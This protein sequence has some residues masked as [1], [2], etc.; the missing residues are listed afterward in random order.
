M[1]VER[2][3]E[4]YFCWCANG[5]YNV[6]CSGVSGFGDSVDLAKMAAL[7]FFYQL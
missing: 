1:R 2:R 7:E 4:D 6:G 3:G 5:T